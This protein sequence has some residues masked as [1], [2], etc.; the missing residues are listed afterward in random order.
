MRHPPPRFFSL[1]RQAEREIAEILANLRRSG[2]SICDVSIKLS[3]AETDHVEIYA[4]DLDEPRRHDEYTVSIGEVSDLTG[5]PPSHIKVLKAIGDPIPGESSVL[6]GRYRLN[7]VERW[8]REE[9]REGLQTKLQKTRRFCSLDE[10][11]PLPRTAHQAGRIL[12]EAIHQRIDITGL[13]RTAG[14]Y[15][16]FDRDSL[17]YVGQA[18]N[19][20][21]RIADHL[22][23]SVKNFDSFAFVECHTEELD[24]IENHFIRA[25]LPPMN[26]NGV[27]HAERRRRANPE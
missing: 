4:H 24:D 27:A 18:V 16:L 15:F 6:P 11:I 2:A 7:C 8:I 17:V 19:I 5:I 14:V 3:A 12:G 21:A 25:L 23:E 9:G 1:V 20:T 10:A 26:S 22:R 13:P